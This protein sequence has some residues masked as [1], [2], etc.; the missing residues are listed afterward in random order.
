MKIRL[1]NLFDIN[2][3]CFTPNIN[4]KKLQFIITKNSFNWKKSM[5]RST[6]LREE[7]IKF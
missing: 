5:K 4:K 1:I 7:K 6:D 3:K 2:G